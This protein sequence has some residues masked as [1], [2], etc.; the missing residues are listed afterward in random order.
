MSGTLRPPTSI[1][2]VSAAGP[3]VSLARGPEA[4]LDDD[5]PADEE[6][7]LHLS[8]CNLPFTRAP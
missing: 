3:L 1:G 5:E 2:L 4:E 6:Q 8:N 7:T